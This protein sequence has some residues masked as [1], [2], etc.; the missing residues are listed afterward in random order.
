MSLAAC[1][2]PPAG[3]PRSAVATA[4]ASADAAPPAGPALR[5]LG[6]A[7]GQLDVDALAALPG[8]GVVQAAP[9]GASA[10]VAWRGVPLRAALQQGFG[11]GWRAAD[12]LLFTCLDGYQP[13]LP[14][15]TALAGAPWLVWAR[16]D[17]AP[18]RH[19]LPGHAAPVAL[20]PLYLVWPG[21]PPEKAQWPYQVTAVE[22]I[23]FSERFAGLVPAADAPAAVR[24]GFDVWRTHCHKCHR[25]QGLGGTIGPELGRPVG[26]LDYWQPAMLRRWLRAP[27]SI[28][29]G[30]PM[31]PVALNEA[32]LDTLFAYLRDRSGTPPGQATP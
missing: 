25:L 16:A 2:P 27:Q 8:A 13:A 4:A 3:R 9:P 14:V 11:A 10:P 7:E 23:N 18:F 12:E 32:E 15:A 24:A 1:E 20:G 26:V 30:S 21:T 31:P 19:T 6:A 22:T 29:E 28:R 5:F 17:G